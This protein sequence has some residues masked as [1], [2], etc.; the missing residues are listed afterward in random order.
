[1]MIERGLHITDFFAFLTFC[2]S[3]LTIFGHVLLFFVD[4]LMYVDLLENRF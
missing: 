1:M 2:Y 4:F 3:F